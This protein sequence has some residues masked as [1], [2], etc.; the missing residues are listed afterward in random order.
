[1]LKSM[2]HLHLLNRHLEDLLEKS[3]PQLVL[4]GSIAFS[5]SDGTIG[6]F[7]TFLAI[8][9]LEPLFVN[10]VFIILVSQKD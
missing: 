3:P 6:G 8:V 7:P 5:L 1:M 2:V 9:L 4:L 10:K